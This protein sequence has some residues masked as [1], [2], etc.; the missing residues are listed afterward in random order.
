MQK[1]T[2]RKSAFAMVLA[3][4]LALAMLPAAAMASPETGATVYLNTTAGSDSNDGQSAAQA[5]KTLDKALELAGEGGTILLGATV[6]ISADKTLANVTIGRAEGFTGTMLSVSNAALTLQDATIDGAG[7]GGQGKYLVTVNTGATLNI[8]T[9]AALQNNGG[10]AVSVVNGTLQMTGGTIAQNESTEDGGAIYMWNGKATL[11][12]GV[13]EDNTTDRCGGGVCVL[14][15]SEI[16]LSGVTIRNNTAYMDGGGVYIEANYQGTGKSKFTMTGGAV[17]GNQTPEGYAGVCVMDSACPVEVTMTG[18]TISNNINQDD[19]DNSFVLGSY[20]EG[21]TYPV[22]KISGSPNITGE[23]RLWDE[24]DLGASI[25]VT[26]AFDPVNPLIISDMYGTEGRAVVRYAQGVTPDVT[27]FGT[28]FSST[29]LKVNGQNIEWIDL[30]RVRFYNALTGKQMGTVYAYPNEPL[31]QSKIPASTPLT[32]YTMTGWQ[33][34]AAD[35]TW[36]VWDMSAPVTEKMDMYEIWKLNAPSAVEIVADATHAHPG[37]TI[38]LKA[39]A[40]HDLADMV[41]NYA[42]YKDGVLME[43]QTT[44]TLT[45]TEAGS[46]TVKVSVYNG[47]VTSEEVESAAVVCEFGHT[48]V[49]G[50]QSDENGHWHACT[51]CEEKLEQAAHV[52]DGGKV[53]TA[54]TE[55][56]TGVKTYTCTVC[57]RV[58]KTETLPVVEAPKTGESGTALWM[59]LLALG[60][61]G[62]AAGVVLQRKKHNA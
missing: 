21:L 58:L 48:L 41:Y 50:W 20:E 16:T 43:G 39:N 52:S 4:A 13:I 36:K 2:W 8:G 56:S 12:G 62:V 49:D 22:L 9:G 61:A 14:G 60:M 15:D 1:R 6:S 33:Y 25:E 5:V 26:G 57:G 55:T 10:T 53:T 32:G 38:T 34:K 7:G 47:K 28:T 37:G 45:V 18:G 54:P 40:S 19:E 11:S 42:W 3:A 27:D 30:F 51:G 29:G 59:A 17:T 46:Y 23:I 35:G 24:G 31:D 44:N